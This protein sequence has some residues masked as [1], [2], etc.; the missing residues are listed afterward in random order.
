MAN[1]FKLLVQ[2]FHS[3]VSLCKYVCCFM[4]SSTVC[5]KC[6]IDILLKSSSF[7]YHNQYKLVRKYR[8]RWANS[9]TTMHFE[10]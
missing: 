3:F 9:L 7:L 1:L 6:M 10:K 8:N 4:A 2:F 5:K